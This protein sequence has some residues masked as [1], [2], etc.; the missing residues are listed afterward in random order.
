MV[1]SIVRRTLPS[2]ARHVA[3]LLLA[4]VAAAGDIEEARGWLKSQDLRLR[5]RAVD[6]LLR[7]DSAEAASELEKAVAAAQREADRLAPALDRAD[8][9]YAEAWRETA[10]LE[11]GGMGGTAE[12]RAALEARHSL[13]GDR[14]RAA[15]DMRL[16]HEL[17]LRA[18]R[19]LAALRSEG[20][21]AR[22]EAGALRDGE[23]AMRL[24]FV[25]ALEGR[26]PA[27]LLRLLAHADARVRAAAVRA[28]V[29]RAGDAPVRQ[30]VRPLGED[31]A[32]PVRLGAHRL[33]AC[34]PPA[35]A[36]EHLAF[37]AAREEGEIAA[38]VDALLER[39]TGR[40]FR[41]SPKQWPAWF[42]ENAEA[43]R[44]G[45]YVRPAPKTESEGE[46]GT[47]A[48]FFRVPIVSRNVVFVLDTSGSM[49]KPMELDD[50]R[51]GRLR[52]KYGL[53]ATRLG[54]AKAE[55]LHAL[56][57]LPDG[58]RF[59][60]VAYSDDARA[61]SRGPLTMAAA[62]RDRARKWV[63]EAEPL[64]E[65]NLWAGLRAAFGDCLDAAPRRFPELPDTVV[66]LTDGNANRGRLRSAGA[67]LDAVRHW[68]YALG[69]VVHCV[70]IGE[71]QDRELLRGLALET[72]G[73][74][75][76]LSGAAPALEER[77]RRLPAP[78]EE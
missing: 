14:T 33:L 24:F 58:A 77:R 17:M 69:V 28:L 73:F 23:F 42:R 30:A 7:A 48:T 51:I 15:E 22:V 71:E 21:L 43:L 37:A 38:H 56:S 67:L 32:W 64:G 55:L 9:A 10:R 18:G 6:L 72:G 5:V 60:L 61:F 29:P 46:R 65:T 26:D 16:H 75:A 41:D 68:N 39:L 19:G 11:T 47:E 31:P 59:N 57:A 27:P 78:L 8:A 25:Q 66:F 45:T 35:E 62:S 1:P 52:G 4:G 53:P 49:A 12:H 36:V 20:A 54:F 34:G 3:W 76:D 70:G 74:L 13:E 63:L 2:H 44:G 50:A 40:S